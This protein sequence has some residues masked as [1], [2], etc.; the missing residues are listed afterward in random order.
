MTASEIWLPKPVVV[1][2]TL[3]ESWVMKSDARTSDNFLNRP[4]PA[5][6][7]I[8]PDRPTISMPS[9]AGVLS[10]RVSNSPR[11]ATYE[12]CRCWFHWASE[13]IHSDAEAIPMIIAVTTHR[14]AL[15]FRLDRMR[16]R[17]RTGQH[18]LRKR[19]RHPS[20]FAEFQVISDS[21]RFCCAGVPPEH[22]APCRSCL[23][24]SDHPW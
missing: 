5:S 15:L 7:A 8:G 6:F 17:P 13:Y 10:R 22:Q 2:G 9:F 16:I 20:R 21:S 4:A 18:R 12:V 19:S 23:K 3:S 1:G 24:W 11:P 14:M